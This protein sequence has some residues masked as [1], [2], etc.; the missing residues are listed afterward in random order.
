MFLAEPL[1]DIFNSCLSQGVY[2]KV[3]KIETV[4]PVPKK[5]E[6]QVLT[7]VR[8]IASTSDF[9]K[10]FEK[11]IKSWIME[12]ISDNLKKKP[13]WREKGVGNRTCSCELCG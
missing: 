13:I 4:T 12:D 3:W 11:Y 8:K 10:I 9:S 5:T 7:D 2:P 6:P 1:T